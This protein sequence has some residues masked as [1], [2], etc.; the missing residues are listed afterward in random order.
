MAD[1]IPLALDA[2]EWA[3]AL[4]EEVREGLAYEVT[5]LW[6]RSRPAAAI[7]LANAAL[8]DDDPRKITREDVDNLRGI[9]SGDAWA[10]AKADIKRL[11]DTL[12]SYLPPP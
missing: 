8:P 10:V 11:A 4:D 5:Y 12:E 1:P 7:A 9:L 3:H 6:G 2:A